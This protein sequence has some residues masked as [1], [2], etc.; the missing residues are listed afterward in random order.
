MDKWSSGGRTLYL[1]AARR[2]VVVEG[3]RVLGE[4]MSCNVPTLRLPVSGAVR[5]SGCNAGYTDRMIKMMLSYTLVL[6]A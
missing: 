2:H 5:S 4:S 3:G 6:H 1:G